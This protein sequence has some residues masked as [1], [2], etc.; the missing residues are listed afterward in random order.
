MVQI[1]MRQTRISGLNFHLPISSSTLH[2]TFSLSNCSVPLSLME[3]LRLGFWVRRGNAFEIL[4]HNWAGCRG[5]WL[6]KYVLSRY[7][8]PPQFDISLFICS[9]KINT[10]TLNRSVAFQTNYHVCFLLFSHFRIYSKVLSF[11]YTHSL[12]HC[13]RQILPFTQYIFLQQY[14]CISVCTDTVYVLLANVMR[15]PRTLLLTVICPL[16]ED[17]ENALETCLLHLR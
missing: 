5:L 7:F 13:P 3:E 8:N 2:W 17:Q 6:A 1:R 15:T 12:I 10:A 16:G 9:I 4:P 11:N 14:F